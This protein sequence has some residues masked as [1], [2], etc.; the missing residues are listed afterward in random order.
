MAAFSDGPQ[1]LGWHGSV[2]LANEPIGGGGQPA[3]ARIVAR[4]ADNR[5]GGSVA[6]RPVH[7]FE[8]V[9]TE[10]LSPQMVRVVLGSPGSATGFDTFKPSQFTDSYVKLVFVACDV[11]IA[12]LPQPLT[13]DSFDAL[14]AGGRPVIR[15]RSEER[16]VGKEC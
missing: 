1:F 13:L 14:S 8:V 12:A 15:T 6:S 7:T 11:D 10:Q 5:D 2:P 3:L 4:S 9:R 16:R